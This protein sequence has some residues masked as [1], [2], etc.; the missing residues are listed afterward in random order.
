MRTT[1]I[2]LI[3]LLPLAAFSQNK[4]A[5]VSGTIKD[6]KTGEIL[7][8]TT[9]FVQDMPG[10]GVIANDYGFYS[11]S[12]PVGTHTLI[13]QFVGYSSIK[14]EIDLQESLKLNIELGESETALDE[15]VLYAEKKDQNITSNEGSVTRL[16]LSE[17]ENIPVLMGERDIL[18][19]VQLTPGV[20]AAGEGNSGF[21]V[22]GGGLDQNLILLD[23][24]P[25]YNPSHL[26]GFFSV[27]NSDALRDVTVYKGGMMPEYGGRTS[28]VMDISMKEG[29]N[30]DLDVTGG[31]GLISSRLTVEAPIVKEKGSFMISGRRT[32]ADLFLGL[33]ND[34][35]INGSKLYFYDL[36]MK[37]NYQLG[38][39]DRIYISGYFGRDVFGFG[40]DFGFNWGNTTGTLR[41]NHLF[42]DKLFSNTSLIYSNYDYKFEFGQGAESLGLESVIR[43]WNFKQDYSLFLNNNNTMKFGYNLIHHRIEPGNLLAGEETGLTAED[44]EPKNSIEG[45]VY[46]Q[47][48][49]KIGSRLRLNY[50]LRYSFFNYTGEGTAYTYDNLGRLTGE[51][52]FEKGESIQYYGGLEP[53]LAANY[54][55]DE[56]SSIKLGYNRNYQYIH[57]LSNA[58]SST[59]TDVWIPSTNN[60][61]PQ[62]A[63]QISLGYFRN[64]GDN[65]FETSVEVY[66]KDMQ[67][68]I[69]YRN[70]ADVF[71]NQNLEGDLV[72]GKGKAYGAEFYVK[73]TS[74]RLTGWVS[75][76][77]SRT[78]RQFDEINNGEWF[79]ARQDRIH[80]LAI[81]A[82]YDLSPKIKL[83]ANF[84]YNTGDAVTFPSGRY[85][86][87]G[88]VV[89]YYT[90]RNGY[91]MPDYHRLDLGV[92]WLKKKT[93]KFESSWT[94]S[95]YNAYGRENAYSINFQQSESNPNV[96]EAVRLALFKAIPSFSYNFKF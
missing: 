78:L 32:Y 11:L 79:S 58:T 16:K 35:T 94:F 86:V 5:Q 88:V 62:I 71:F 76:T 96:T 80:D 1:F 28:S 20:K 42:S 57:L 50:G 69:D 67:N 3:C 63:D 74:G 30:K 19:V 38:Q 84:V 82:M 64:F 85:E 54:G 6:A 60:V 18:K 4:K 83:S 22:R 66:Y 2:F 27:F 52:Q 44:A 87:D 46:I 14:K 72:Y 68:T 51:T 47:N 77:L 29:N 65:K 9:V 31:I 55:I 49:Q 89:P 23:E 81:V 13:Y 33:S 24:A 21:Y 93:E 40:D 59:P 73:K 34:E 95:L 61:K 56:K 90:E 12:L 45:A 26:L 37:A 7:P 25:V 43:D 10:T 15:V 36:N 53:R 70:G 92:T 39:K 91:R 17:V 75:Y 8:G 48:A 41:W